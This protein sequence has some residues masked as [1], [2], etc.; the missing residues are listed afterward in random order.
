MYEV[1]QILR[2]Q[3]PK[4]IPCDWYDDVDLKGFSQPIKDEINTI[5]CSAE[6]SH[7]DW[8]PAVV[9]AIRGLSENPIGVDKGEGALSGVVQSFIK[10]VFVNYANNHGFSVRYDTNTACTVLS[11]T[12]STNT[13]TTRATQTRRDG[14]GYINDVPFFIQ[15]DKKC[16]EKKSEAE[17]QLGENTGMMLS[18]FYDQVPFVVACSVAG[19][20]M[21]F[22]CYKRIG[23]YRYQSLILVQEIK[24][25]RNN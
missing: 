7:H 5:I 11:T 17:K 4:P 12:K 1:G 15:E 3:L 22:Y 13:A 24:V 18:Q 20:I 16:V 21:T 8:G 14:I 6:N 2:Q 9:D 19:P 10:K 25:S 23:N